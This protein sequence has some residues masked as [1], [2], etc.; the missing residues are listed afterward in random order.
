MTA[1]GVR[2]LFG[3]DG[4]RAVAGES[5]LDANT[6]FACGLA[7]GHSLRKIA[8]A[9]K[10]ILGRDTRESGPWIAATLAAGLRETGVRVES[11]G[12]VPTPAVAF[13]A[14]SHGF[15]AGVVISASHNPWRDNGIKLFGANGFKLADAVE[16]AMEDEIL[17]HATQSVAPDA[18]TL[19][20]VEDNAALQADYIQFLIDCVPGLSLAGLRIVADC[21]N[22]AS[23]AVAPELFRRLGGEVAL[24]NIN[25]DGHN[26]NLNCGA[27]HPDFVA[28]KVSRRGADLG[29]TFDG[30]ADRC[31]LAGAKN[32]VINGDAIL[33]MAARDLKARGLLTGDLVVATTMSNMGLEAALKRSGIRML[34]APVGDRYVLEQM[35]KNNAALG[36]EQSGHILL[37][38]LATTGDGLLTALV[39]LDLIARS[40]KSIDELTADLKVFP[41]VIVNVKVREKKPLE[42]IPAVAGAIRTA[43]AELKDS[44]R[45]V[46]RYSGTEALAR[47]M[48]EAESEETMQL[49]ANAIAD[50]IRAELGI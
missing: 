6:I 1:P 25:P 5:P 48:I 31:M 28:G 37:P 45:V 10:V 3:T 46:I 26:I 49:H 43:E 27:L 39:V 40:G 19:P 13:L 33:L 42:S 32:N 12:V 2:K 47:V 29:L 34:R 44:G 7:L 50:A 35:L 11:A 8:A 38:H 9:P 17:H 20:A 23:T 18:A 41:Q 24:L 15:Q 22:G 30:D 14:R 21:A 16:L 36:G 4:I